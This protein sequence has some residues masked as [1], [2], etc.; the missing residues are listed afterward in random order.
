M[1]GLSGAKENE[2]YANL[3]PPKVSVLRKISFEILSKL[4]P[5]VLNTDFEVFEK[6]LGVITQLGWKKAEREL[7]KKYWDKTSTELHKI[8]AN[9]VGTSSSGPTSYTI[10]DA[11]KCNINKIKKNL[12]SALSEDCEIVIS[13]I[14]NSGY[15]VQNF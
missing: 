5:A 4:V 12:E 14:N 13:S 3:A 1:G 9:F 8:G 11:N 7:F 6:S 15:T 10:L 2:F